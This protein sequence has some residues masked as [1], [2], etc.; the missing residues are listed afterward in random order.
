MLVTGLWFLTTGHL[1]LL[2]GHERLALEKNGLKHKA[3]L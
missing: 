1:Y 3:S 2:D